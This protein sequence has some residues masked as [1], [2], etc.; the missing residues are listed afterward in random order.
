MK[1]ILHSYDDSNEAKMYSVRRY[2]QHLHII[3]RIINRLCDITKEF[4]KYM[5]ICCKFIYNMRKADYGDR[6]NIMMCH[7]VECTKV[8]WVVLGFMLRTTENL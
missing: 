8:D 4:D 3:L 1:I 6:I 2:I 7:H 5:Q